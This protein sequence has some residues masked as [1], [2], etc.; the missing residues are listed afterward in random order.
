NNHGSKS[1][2]ELQNHRYVPARS[3]SPNLEFDDSET[4]SLPDSA[5]RHDFEVYQPTSFI[6]TPHNSNS[7]DHSSA[8]TRKNLRYHQRQ[9]LPESK[10][11]KEGDLS[12]F[13]KILFRS[14]RVINPS[15]RKKTFLSQ[16]RDRLDILVG[17]LSSGKKD[18][19]YRSA[20][21]RRRRE[22]TLSPRSTEYSLMIQETVSNSLWDEYSR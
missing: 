17:K 10:P 11:H 14:A 19:D 7:Q 9:S 20:Q 2:G 4:A 8:L 15:K 3:E 16:S 13:F 18:E 1:Q 21:Q 22:G 6:F 12:S 5:A